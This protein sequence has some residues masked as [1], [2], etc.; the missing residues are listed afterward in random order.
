[1][2]GRLNTLTR[3]GWESVVGYPTDDMDSKRTWKSL[4][5]T[6]ISRTLKKT[7]DTR[8]PLGS[9]YSPCRGDA[10][11][12]L[13]WD[14]MLDTSDTVQVHTLLYVM[15]YAAYLLLSIPLVL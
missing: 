11:C 7:P 1:M 14:L 5:A 10:P 12:T 2:K 6:L 4:S 3:P 9:S 13:I 8:K 15:C